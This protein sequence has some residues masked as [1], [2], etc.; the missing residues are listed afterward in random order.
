MRYVLSYRRIERE[1]EAVR[2]IACLIAM[3]GL[4]VVPAAAAESPVNDN[5]ASALVLAT[6]PAA[7]DG[8]TVGATVVP[9]D[10]VCG[11]PMSATVWYTL[12]RPDD[13]TVVVNFRANGDL[14]AVVAALRVVPTGLKTLV[15]V[16]SDKRGRAG[17]SFQGEKGAAYMILV[18]QRA[19]SAAGT[20][21][22]AV[23]APPR[24]SNDDP[25]AA[26]SLARLPVAVA[27]TTL[28]GSTDSQ[29]PQCEELSADVWYRLDR[30]AA[31]ETVVQ[32]R[33]GGDL[34]ATLAV[35]Q[36]VR[37]QLERISCDQTDSRGRADLSVET[38]KGG[39]Y[40]IA[41]GQLRQSSPGRFVL[42]V[43][44][45]EAPAIGPGVALVHGTASASVDALTDRDD[46][47]AL[48]MTEGRTYRLNLLGRTSC[49]SM[50][51]YEPGATRFGET[52]PIRYARCGGYLTF[53]PGPDRSG[54][55]SVRVTP[56][57]SEQGAQRY[58]L[59]AAPAGPDD[60]GP[61]LNLRSGQVRRGGLDGAGIDVVDLYRFDVPRLSDV[62]LRLTLP[63]RGG[64]AAAVLSETGGRIGTQHIRDRLRVRVHPGRYFVTLRAIQPL[65][66]RY[67]LGLQIR[68][69]T[70][71]VVTVDG[72]TATTIPTPRPVTLIVT[73]TP[74]S[75]S[76]GIVRITVGYLDPLQGWV[77]IK[78]FKP[79]VK[80]TQATVHFLPPKIGRY[81]IRARFYG[82]NA[83][84]PSTSRSAILLV[85]PPV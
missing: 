75:A 16:V 32:L 23:Q 81:G 4:M 35:Y 30:K 31:G 67:S 70:R 11:A 73:V 83:A 51:L 57:N 65:R 71:T 21:R 79:R 40:L 28:G 48:P 10:P 63:K 72:A 19:N 27:G 61:G 22:L 15:C 5:Q 9:S 66:A 43:F 2:G 39:R 58:V 85:A 37:S 45:P 1:G 54:V 47:Y 14:D 69:I 78:Q 18:G 33:A 46:A 49:V 3:A 25:A 34:D 29:T 36:R 13:L 52:E 60:I 84:S 53:T 80:G 44:A 76:G 42:R 17:F 82:S 12:T 26:R 6:L 77:F 62:D 50:G 74:S 41:V 55:Y 20:F 59:H 24:P 7:A 38:E 8:T 68:D 56:S 64:V